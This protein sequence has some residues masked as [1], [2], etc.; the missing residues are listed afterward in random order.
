MNSVSF[1]CTW[2]DDAYIFIANETQ[3]FSEFASCV[4][5]S[6]LAAVYQCALSLCSLQLRIHGELE[7]KARIV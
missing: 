3:L 7:E 4:L 1:L 2:T 5:A 6:S